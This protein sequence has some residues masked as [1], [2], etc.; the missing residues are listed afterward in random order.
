MEAEKSSS[1]EQAGQEALLEQAAG[2]LRAGSRR[3]ARPLN[4]QRVGHE[5]AARR[6]LAAGQP[7]ELGPRTTGGS[8]PPG[9]C[10]RSGAPHRP[11]DLGEP[12]GDHQ[13]RRESAAVGASP[14][15][16]GDSG[17]PGANPPTAVLAAVAAA[18]LRRAAGPRGGGRR[19]GRADR[20]H[21]VRRAGAGRDARHGRRA[22]GHQPGRDCSALDGRFRVERASPTLVVS[23]LQRCQ[24]DARSMLRGTLAF[25]PDAS[26]GAGASPALAQPHA[27]AQPFT[28][29][30][31]GV[32][33]L[34]IGRRDDEARG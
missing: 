11:G 12:R 29:G 16:G 27:A 19:S 3:D 8:A 34:A 18:R 10:G 24:R 25:T 1:R 4:R 26:L 31:G 15:A 20:A 28:A 30:A 21:A 32:S 6:D 9:D 5:P 33:R 22:A 17:R 13:S 7:T 2:W 14:A 23:F